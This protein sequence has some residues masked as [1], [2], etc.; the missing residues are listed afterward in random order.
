MF[1]NSIISSHTHLLADVLVEVAVGASLP[2]KWP[3]DIDAAFNDRGGV[4]P[5]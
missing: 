3:V 4:T 1:L 5:E 2:A